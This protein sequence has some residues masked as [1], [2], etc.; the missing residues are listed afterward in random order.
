MTYTIQEEY[1]LPS[2]GKLYN[3]PFDPT[4]KLRSMTVAD[5]MKRLQ[6]SDNPY[7]VMSEIIDD[8]LITKL[9]AKS[10]EA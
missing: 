7:K 4:I 2:K 9:S 8:C 10:S 1:V 3:V 5:E 6:V